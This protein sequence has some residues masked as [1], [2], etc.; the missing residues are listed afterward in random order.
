M[1]IDVENLTIA[2][3][4][5]LLVSVRNGDEA[6][7]ALAGG[8]GIIDIKEPHRGSLGMADVAEIAAVIAVVDGRA[9]VSAALGEA[10]DW[11]PGSVPAL[12]AG[13]QFAKLGMAGLGS[14]GVGRWL[15][16]R[17][18]FSDR[19]P[20]PRNWV[21]VAYADWKP[22]NAPEPERIIEAAAES[23]CRVVLFDTFAKSGSTLLDRVT[24]DE[25][26]EWMEQIHNAG[27]QAALAGG[28]TRENLATLLPLGAEII[29]IRGAAC[30]GGLRTGRIC[31]ES[32]R[33]F[34]AAMHSGGWVA[35]P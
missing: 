29:G 15:E 16:I 27:M 7:S 35:R 19:G 34:R 30:T 9:P 5:R 11:Q 10:V 18:A 12:P 31:E 28:V 17:R 13:L 24:V 1:S 32:I 25:L 2:C 4:P 20:S 23:D 14:N 3:G 8:C 26:E 6:R 33:G 21:A 22:A